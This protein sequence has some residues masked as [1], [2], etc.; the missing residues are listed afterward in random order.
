MRTLFA[1]TIIFSLLACLEIG[2]MQQRINKEELEKISNWIEY[3]NMCDN[4][5]KFKNN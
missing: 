3:K 5:K 4:M 2:R 1:I